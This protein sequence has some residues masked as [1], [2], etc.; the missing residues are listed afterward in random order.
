MT[1]KSIAAAVLLAAS[2]GSAGAESLDITVPLTGTG[3]TLTAGF[4]LTHLLSGAFI[5]TITFTPSVGQSLVDASLITLGLDVNNIDF[6][7]VQLNGTPMTITGS[8]GGALEYSGILQS[9]QSGLLRLTV[10]GYAGPVGAVEGTPIN[11][12]Y[13]GTMNI[14]PIPEPAT[15]GMLIGGLGVL[16]F[17][18]RRRNT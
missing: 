17:L 4:S 8:G 9:T 12:V 6:Y 10:T 14:N 15:Y 1:F 16:A 11:A 5:D 2:V 3:S 7:T 13:A 18:A